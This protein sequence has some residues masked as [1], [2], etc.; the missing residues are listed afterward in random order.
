MNEKFLKVARQGHFFDKHQKV[1]VAVSGGRDSMTLLNLLLTHKEVLNIEIGIAHINHKQ[2]EESDLEEAELRKIA[3]NL[4]IPIFVQQYP[5][6]TFSEKKAR[7]VRYQFFKKIMQEENYTALVT[8]HHTDDQAETV[9]MRLLRGSRLLH[10]TGI[11]QVQ[12][13]GNG[14][15]IRPL[16]SFKKDELETAVYFEDASNHQNDYLRNRIRNIYLPQL[17]NENVRFSEHLCELAAES[18]LFVQAIKDLST[19]IDI[20]DLKEFHQQT[21]AVQA[22]LFQIYLEDF[23]ELQLTKAQFEEVLGI[24]RT[25]SNYYH[26]LKNDYYLQ[27]DDNHFC[28]TKIR[29]ETEES[30]Q[31][32]V[33]QS[34]G[35]FEYRDFFFG[36]NQPIENAEQQLF[37]TSSAPIILRSRQSG[38]KIVINGVQ[39]KIRRYFIDQKISLEER[40]KAII[41]EQEEKILGIANIVSSDLSKLSKDAIIKDTL[42]IKMKE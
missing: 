40:K 4:H 35:I 12:T 33:I 19:N 16:L 38:D 8:A 41:I 15:L 26:H 5:F 30:F 17:S 29:P 18:S 13:F 25:K 32:Y 14:Q 34:E 36:Y 6:E 2:R 11:S 1:L 3:A 23:P 24:L 42:Y 7:D 39:K 27:K 10:L 28:I 21:H 22:S 9:F 20:T 37:I 31:S